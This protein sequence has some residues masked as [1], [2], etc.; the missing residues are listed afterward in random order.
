MEEE[1]DIYETECNDLKNRLQDSERDFVEVSSNYDRDR[2]LWEDKF[3]FL[4]NQKNQSKRDLQD[5]HSK[6]EMTVEQLQ[7]KDSSERGKNESAQMLLINSIEKKYR[8]QIKDMN[9]S[10]T[11]TIHDYNMRYKK[12]ENEYKEIKEK[13]EIETRG[14]TSEYG[15]M[16]K[17]LKDLEEGKH[18]MM[19]EI[20]DLKNQRDR[21]T[22]ENQ[23]VLERE[24]EIY[25]N[26]IYELEEKFKQTESKRSFQLFEFEKER[27]KW[28]LEK[29]KLLQ[30]L[31]SSVDQL[32]KAKMKKD[33]AEKDL[34]K[35]KTEYREHRKYL[36]S[37][38]LNSSA[39]IKELASDRIKMSKAG[40]NS[41]SVSEGVSG[42][43]SYRSTKFSKN[44]IGDY[45]KSKN[46]SYKQ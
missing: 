20:K 18:R 22:L 17:K 31:E 37:S 27:A 34:N 14:Q 36:M 42:V 41:D 16:I 12:L 40:S 28:T 25:K 1:L 23:S 8:D 32:K 39:A 21:K 45:T 33:K 44:Y 13:Y 10:H 5:A 7:R 2:A 35:L 43:R 6:F 19:E 15:S 4:E 38:N 29:D 11:Q 26:R 30:E 46:S 24:K 3:E 9:D